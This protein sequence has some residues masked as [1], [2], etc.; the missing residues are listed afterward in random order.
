LSNFT[1]MIMIMIIIIIIIIIIR[2]GETA[3]ITIN[4]TGPWRCSSQAPWQ[5]SVFLL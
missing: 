2:M 3:F 4:S 1:P 5:R